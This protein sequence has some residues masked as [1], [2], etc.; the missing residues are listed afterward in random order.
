MTDVSQQIPFQIPVRGGSDHRSRRAARRR[1]YLA[2][3]AVVFLCAL[4]L[5]FVAWA[6]RA[7]RHLERP[8]IGPVRSAWTQAAI[9]TPMIL[10]A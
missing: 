1:E 7:A 4:P 10:S 9:I 8:E 5:A 3:F 6:L 2:Y